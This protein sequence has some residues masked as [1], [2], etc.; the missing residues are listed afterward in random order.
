VLLPTVIVR[1]SSPWAA[2]KAADALANGDDKSSQLSSCDPD[3]EEL[4][5]NW[6]LKLVCKQKASFCA[7]EN[8]VL[9]SVR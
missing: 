1:G 7:M 2:S 9:V 3:K 5:G 4:R 8:W 6:V